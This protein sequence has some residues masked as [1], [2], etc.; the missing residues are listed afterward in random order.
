MLCQQPV[1][2]HVCHLPL[3]SAPKP[4]LLRAGH[5]EARSQA[6]GCCCRASLAQEQAAPAS[7]PGAEPQL[8]EAV[9]FAPATVANLGPGFDWM[10]C[11]VEVSGLKRKCKFTDNAGCGAIAL[12][13]GSGR[14]SPCGLRFTSA[15]RRGHSH[16]AGAPGP[17]GRSAD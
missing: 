1:A 8:R 16:G 15:G 4:A 6:A 11:A 12:L 7:R 5:R 10:G 9:A 14:C 13:A 3:R 17:P 2:A